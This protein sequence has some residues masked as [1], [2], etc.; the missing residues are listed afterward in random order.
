MKIQ[1]KGNCKMCR[2]PLDIYMYATGC[3]GREAR[4]MNTFVKMNEPLNFEKNRVCYKFSGLK[5]HRVC[6]TCFANVKIAKLLAFPNFKLTS[7]P[8][9]RQSQLISPSVTQEELHEIYLRASAFA[10]RPDVDSYII[11]DGY[12]GHFYECY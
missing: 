7:N 5:L 1:W 9:P 6:R 3:G 11:D 10:K 4:I 8:C 12:D 2:A